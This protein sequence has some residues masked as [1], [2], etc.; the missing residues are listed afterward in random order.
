METAGYTALSRQ[1][2]LMREMRVI[3]N[4][5]ANANTTGYRQQGVIFSE[6]ITQGDGAEAVAMASA[7]VRNT[8]FAQ[9]TLEQTGGQLDFGIEGDGFF[10]VGTPE[11][12]RLT[13]AG[14]F[15]ISGAGTLVTPDGHPV[16][17][18]GGAPILLPPLATDLAVARDGTISTEG[19]P[20]GQLA[21]MRPLDPKGMVREGNTLFW[22]EAG[23]E[24]V[25]DPRVMQGFVEASNV[26]PILQ[27]T[28]M[29]E[30]QRAYELGQTFME[31][32]DE[33]VRAALNTFVK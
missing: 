23:I 11:G 1:S 15:A 19:R 7:R 6:Y 5:I 24:P 12:E 8:S 17:D 10:L 33:R 26:D 25:A 9:G 29:V 21:I 22:A 4:N 20:V 28:R 31:R 27:I 32:E 3:A 18:A 13:R 2:S 14:A 16:L 30:V